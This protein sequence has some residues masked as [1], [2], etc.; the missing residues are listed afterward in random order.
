M[1]AMHIATWTRTLSKIEDSIGPG[2][3]DG[4]EAGASVAMERCGW[5]KRDGRKAEQ[6]LT[7]IL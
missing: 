1:E 7:N 4:L 5:R 3:A 2:V 6:I